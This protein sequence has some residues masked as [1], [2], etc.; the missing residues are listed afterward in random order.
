MSKFI[1]DTAIPPRACQPVL[2]PPICCAAVAVW[3][4]QLERL[5]EYASLCRYLAP[6]QWAAIR[7]NALAFIDQHGAEAHRLG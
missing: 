1:Q 5:S 4:D 7:A 6:A 2:H 3:R